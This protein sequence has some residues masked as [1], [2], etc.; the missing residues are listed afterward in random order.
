MTKET[1]KKTATKVGT[2][3][4]SKAAVDASSSLNDIPNEVHSAQETAVD[5]A[6][7]CVDS[8]AQ[9]VPKF[10]ER[11]LVDGA[12]SPNDV[13]NTAFDITRKVIDAQLDITQKVAESLTRPR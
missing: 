3:T 7:S 1:K 9:L 2:T 11:P 5:V 12:P 13:T 4:R 6:R 10:W 8:V